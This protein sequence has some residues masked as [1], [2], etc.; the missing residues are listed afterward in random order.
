MNIPKQSPLKKIRENCLDC[1]GNQYSQ[2]RLCPL[3]DCPLWF[4]R[5]GKMPQTIIKK[6]GV[7]EAELFNPANFADGGKFESCIDARFLKPEGHEHS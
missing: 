3:T 6:G 2:V 1:C 5:L 4:L 7:E